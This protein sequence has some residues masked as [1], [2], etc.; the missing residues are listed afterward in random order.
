MSVRSKGSNL[1]IIIGVVCATIQGIVLLASGSPFDFAHKISKFDLIPPLWMWCLTLL[2]CSFLAGYAF[3]AALGDLCGGRADRG[4]EALIYQGGML[5]VAAYLLSLMH[6]PIL[7]VEA[8]LIAALII[9][10][11]ALVLYGCCA[12]LWSRPCVM[13]SILI[14]VCAVW[15]GYVFL[16]T[17]H[18][19]FNI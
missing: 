17:G 13:P 8:K 2:I 14:S 19:I 4:G 6:Y 9:S 12:F 3:G 11:F 7:F 5:F 15:S 1:S 10:L 18:L 16:V